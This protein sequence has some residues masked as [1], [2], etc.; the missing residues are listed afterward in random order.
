MLTPATALRDLSFAALLACLLA[1]PQPARADGD[2]GPG[3]DEALALHLVCQAESCH[4]SPKLST[5]NSPRCSDKSLDG[6]N[7]FYD[8]EY[9]IPAIVPLQINLERA[10]H[11]FVAHYGIQGS[12]LSLEITGAAELV[13]AKRG[14]DARLPLQDGKK[15]ALKSFTFTP[16][17]KYASDENEIELTGTSSP[18]YKIEFPFNP[19]ETRA[20]FVHPLKRTLGDG[21]TVVETPGIY[22]QC[23]LEKR[24]RNTPDPGFTVLKGPGKKKKRG[25]AQQ[26]E[27]R[28][29]PQPQRGSSQPGWVKSSLPPSALKHP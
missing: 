18:G 23:S 21:V 22:F 15:S 24:L 25:P 20:T 28:S 8:K 4:P 5:P 14:E 19:K 9:E 3:Q 16:S 17:F 11:L 7:R 29:K 27:G 6:E 2:P 13:P 1:S 26:S 12:D 10:P